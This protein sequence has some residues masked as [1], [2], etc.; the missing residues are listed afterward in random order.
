[1]KQKT[2]ELIEACRTALL[3]L[4][5]NQLKTH[6]GSWM[7]MLILGD[8]FGKGIDELC[9]LFG[10]Q[11]TSDSTSK[12][13]PTY[14]SWRADAT[15]PL[16]DVANVTLTN[17][18][19]LKHKIKDL[20]LDKLQVILEVIFQAETFEATNE[21]EPLPPTGTKFYQWLIAKIDTIAKNT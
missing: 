10:Y 9:M 19:G 12:T 6:I 1:M 8:K 21:I 5:D 13:Y 4:D 15:D 7:D 11:V 20:P 3:T 14:S 18:A 17:H 2:R 16:D